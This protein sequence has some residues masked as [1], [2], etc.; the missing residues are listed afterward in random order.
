MSDDGDSVPIVSDVE[1]RIGKSA[2]PILFAPI[3]AD[4]PNQIKV[5]GAAGN[6]PGIGQIYVGTERKA[7][8]GNCELLRNRE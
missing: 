3:D 4:G 7:G 1:K 2:F 5:T 8:T 6:I